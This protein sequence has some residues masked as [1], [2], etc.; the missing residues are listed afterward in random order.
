MGTDAARTGRWGYAAL[1]AFLLLYPFPYQ[2]RLNNP[3][4]NVRLYMTAALV[5]H[6]TYAI[7]RMRER[8]GWVNDAATRDGHVYS[9][10]APG[11]SWLGVP[12]YAAYL[13]LTRLLGIAFD[14]TV[15]LWVCRAT[16]T[17][18]PFWL[19][20]WW[21]WRWLDTQ[22]R[23]APLRDAAFVSVAFGSLLYGYG[24]LF[25]SHTL[26][27]LAAFVAFIGL[28]E[29][30]RAST[31]L[32]P[33]Q[34]FWLGTL[35]AW[36]TVL[37]Y[38]GLVASLVLAA[39][40]AWL[41]RLKP[42]LG[43]FAAGGLLPALAMMH[44]Q[45]SAFGSPFSPGHL[46]V[47]ND[48]FR[49]AHEQGLYGAVGPTWSS[50]HGLLFDLGAGLF[51]L[52]PL[53][54]FAV[55][56]F[57]WM[58][59]SVNDRVAAWFAIALC[60]LTL[61]SI[62]SMNNWRGGWTV[63]PRYL[64]VLVPFMAWAALVAFNRFAGRFPRTTFSLASGCAL[65]G[66]IA[67]GAPSVYYPHLPP[68]FTRPLP[69]LIALLVAHDYAPLNAG[70][71]LGL[72]GSLSMLPLSIAALALICGGLFRTLRSRDAVIVLLG[73]LAIGS[74]FL[75]P[76]VLRPDVEPGVSNAQAFVTRR[77]T[78]EGHDRAA[79]LEQRLAI[80]ERSGAVHRSAAA[81]YRALAETYRKEGRDTEELRTD[82]RLSRILGR[83]YGSAE[84]QRER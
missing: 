31:P 28:R 81:T 34:A 32:R 60:C 65:A 57:F 10:K 56:G 68:E 58:A 82:R 45:W 55:P 27:A 11:T 40:A 6:G 36:V 26:S 33:L 70:H 71:W 43:W 2:A 50:L 7:D 46:M 35:T 20:L 47:E 67:S 78:P 30:A 5:E 22:T 21:L 64:A 49:S 52:T 18:L 13:G 51:P 4:E 37:E 23:H 59:R 42:A 53:L 24:L 83:T 9:V 41:L 15:A 84:R 54:V 74:A 76:L 77:W 12:G 73:S 14:R 72:H 1:F 3:N 66:L 29:T 25:V 19:G 62:A 16:G 8:W 48:A 61:L 75:A 69:Q 38:P 80:T 17:I 44:F 39:Y 79:R 63:G